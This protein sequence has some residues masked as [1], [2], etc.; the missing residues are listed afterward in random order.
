MTHCSTEDIIQPLLR[1]E[2]AKW[3]FHFEL[4]FT[5]QCKPTVSNQIFPFKLICSYRSGRDEYDDAQ[6]K[7]NGSQKET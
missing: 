3:D 7:L 1:N 5:V 2:S 4:S 6:M